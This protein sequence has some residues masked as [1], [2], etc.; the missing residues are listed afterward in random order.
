M[1]ATA[2]LSMTPSERLDLLAGEHT[3][4]VVVSRPAGRAPLATPVWYDVDADG[5]VVF[6][7]NARS[8]KAALIADGT[9]VAFLVQDEAPPQRF[10]TLA[11]PA[12]VEVATD[13]VRRRIARRYLDPNGIENFVAMTPSCELVAITI[14]P[15]TWFST[16]FAK[17]AHGPTVGG[18]HRSTGAPR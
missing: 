5:N 11:G 12:T 9:P 4:I 3:G 10:V 16:D 2:P 6:V 8:R 14:C 18:D 15:V 13:D 17:V 7:T 1:T